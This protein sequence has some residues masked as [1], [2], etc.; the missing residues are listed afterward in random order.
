MD[1]T[2]GQI[3]A[4]GIAGRTLFPPGWSL[5]VHEK[6]AN[7]GLKFDRGEGFFLGPFVVNHGVTVFGFLPLLVIPYA[8]GFI[9]SRT[10]LTIAGIGILALPLLL[11]RLT[12][13]RWLTGCFFSPAQTVAE[14]R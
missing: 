5:R 1:V 3:L 8:A 14:S 6:C 4:R 12:W 10:A 9:G 13:S 7:C 11:Y 2:R